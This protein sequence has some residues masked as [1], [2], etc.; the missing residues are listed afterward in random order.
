[1]DQGEYP[2]FLPDGRHFI[3]HRDSALY[4]GSLDS[5][6]SARLVDA[7][8]QAAYFGG[9]LVYIREDVLMAQPFDVRKLAVSGDPMP[10]ARDVRMGTPRVG[11]FSLSQTGML[12][13]QE[14]QRR[15][16]L[17]SFDR[18]GHRL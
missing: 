10:V 7:E 12:V 17:S 15:L 14:G 11:V 4:V 6:K 8:S 9:Y 1:L 13:Y 3:F 5:K 16:R 18:S 2:N